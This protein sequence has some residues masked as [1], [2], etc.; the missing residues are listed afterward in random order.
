MPWQIPSGEKSGH[1]RHMVFQPT[2]DH[3]D[4]TGPVILASRPPEVGAQSYDGCIVMHRLKLARF[5]GVIDQL[6]ISNFGQII[7]FRCRAEH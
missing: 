1:S 2:D 7:L 6:Q 5:F 3:S 4:V